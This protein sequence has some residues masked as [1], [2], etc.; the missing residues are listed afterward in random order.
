MMA[1]IRRPVRWFLASGGIGIL[2]AVLLYVLGSVSYS[3]HFV[4]QVAVVLCPASILGLA[5]PRSF[6]AVSLLLVIVFVTNFV[7]YGIVGLLLCG[8]WS[9]FRYTPTAR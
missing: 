1:S 2:V 6:G 3:R 8:A 7:L 9:L 4:A 5:E